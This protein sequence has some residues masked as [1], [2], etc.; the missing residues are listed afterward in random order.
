MTLLSQGV[1]VVNQIPEQVKLVG[2]GL[3][4]I[5]WVSVLAGVLTQVFGLLAAILSCVWGAVR[6]YE[7]KTVQNWLV[8]RKHK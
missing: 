3:A 5:G 2:D 7:T 8:R 1:R 6:L 4:V